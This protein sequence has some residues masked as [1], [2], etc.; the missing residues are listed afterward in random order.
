M[1]IYVGVHATATP[2]REFPETLE[3]YD[4]AVEF[5]GTLEGVQDGLYYIDGPELLDCGICG[6]QHHPGFAGDCRD[7]DNR[8]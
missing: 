1:S 8:F 6:G 3:G 5:V 4:E 2:L 7:D